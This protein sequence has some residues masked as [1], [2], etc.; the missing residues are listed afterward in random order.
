MTKGYNRGVFRY[1]ECNCAYFSNCDLH[2]MM[3]V[4]KRIVG[5]T[6]SSMRESRL[7]KA[8]LERE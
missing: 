7:E 5:D 2:K 1:E 8:K 3:S 6:T 4:G